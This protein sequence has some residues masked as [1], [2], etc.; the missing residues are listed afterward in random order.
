MSEWCHQIQ[1]HVSV[2]VQYN[3]WMHTRGNVTRNEQMPH[4]AVTF[5][6]TM[7]RFSNGYL[8]RL[9]LPNICCKTEACHVQVLVDA[10]HLLNIDIDK[11][12]VLKPMKQRLVEQTQSK[13][14][15]ELMQGDCAHTLECWAHGDQF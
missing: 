6:Q 11:H 13:Y 2:N 4:N 15:S 5:R 12:H 8:Q 7:Q 14:R 9:M 1:E 3:R 10:T